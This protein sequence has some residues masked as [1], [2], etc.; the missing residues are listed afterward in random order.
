MKHNQKNIQYGVFP[1]KNNTV[2]FGVL[3]PQHVLY[4]FIHNFPKQKFA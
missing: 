1:T 4:F 3:R 2:V